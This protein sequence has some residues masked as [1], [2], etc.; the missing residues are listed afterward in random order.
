MRMSKGAA[1]IKISQIHKKFNMDT[2]HQAGALA[3][4]LRLVLR[5]DA[6]RVLPVLDGVSFDAREGEIVGIV[7]RN[8]SGKSTLLKI[9]ARIYKPDKGQIYTTGKVLYLGTFGQGLVP[10]LTVRENIEFIASL[11][12]LSRKEMKAKFHE[13]IAFSGLNQFIDTKVYQ[14]SSGMTARLAFSTAILCIKHNNPDILLIDEVLGSVGDIEFHE[15]AVAKIEE[16]VRGHATVIMTS[17]NA[18]IIKKYC[19]K[20]LWLDGMRILM[21]GKPEEVIHAY[22]KSF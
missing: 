20:V 12:G 8:G 19:D 1:R 18:D 7:G 4:L 5:R 13:I 3:W 16:L 15:R 6:K 11:M 21:E 10:R 17:H 14:L 2:K 9:I 22:E